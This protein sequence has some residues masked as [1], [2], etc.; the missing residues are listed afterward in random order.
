[1]E[2]SFKYLVLVNGNCNFAVKVSHQ[3]K[4]A[5]NHVAFL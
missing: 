4:F 5:T 2:E 1:M 3:I